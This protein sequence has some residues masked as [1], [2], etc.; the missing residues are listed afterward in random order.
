MWGA[1]QLKL[2][3]LT[4]ATDQIVQNKVRLSLSSVVQ[5]KRPS[6]RAIK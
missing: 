6:L 5:L 2:Q 1:A 3:S 4:R